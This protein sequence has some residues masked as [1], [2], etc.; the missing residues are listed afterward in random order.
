MSH[1]R[2]GFTLVE[3]T[4]VSAMTAT[5]AML[6]SSVWV[7]TNNAGFPNDLILRGRLLQEMDMAVS[8]F[9]RDLGG[10]LAIPSSM[11]DIHQG[12][13]IGWRTLT[14]N[15]V[16]F[17]YDGGA[18]PDG[19]IS[20]TGTPDTVIHYYLDDDPDAS[21]ST[22]ILV[23]EDENAG[24]TFTVAR[25]VDNMEVASES[26]A[27]GEMIKITLTFKSQHVN[28]EYVR[29]CTLNVRAPQ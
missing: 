19:A 21:L 2:R 4:I 12:R 28:R 9:S 8:A 11:D 3:V 26:V 23:R 24:T 6:L 14:D 15:D 22:K 27:G 1:N 13:W 7:W 29:K 17:C 5:L 10:S 16:Q 18:T 20:W 25:F